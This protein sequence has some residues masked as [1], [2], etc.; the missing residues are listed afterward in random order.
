MSNKIE[1]KRYSMVQL[2]EQDNY[3]IEVP[4]IQRDY[5]QGRENKKEIRDQFLDALFNYLDENIPFRDLDFI[6]GNIEKTKENIKFIPLDGQQRLTTLFLLHWYLAMKNETSTEHFNKYF[7]TNNNSRFIYNTRTSSSEFINALL[8]SKIKT[9]EIDE[10]KK[11]SEFIKEQGWFFLSWNLDPTIQA[12]LIMLDS[13]HFKFYNNDNFY[14]RLVSNDKPIITFQY[15]DLMES[16]LSEDLY[17]KM[18]SRGKPLTSFENFKAKLEKHIKALFGD[19]KDKYSITSSAGTLKYSCKDYFSQ[20]I[21]TTW[22][23][24]FW[25]YR[26]LVGKKDIFDE[27]LMNFIRVVLSNQFAVDNPIEI[28]NF[29][30]LI[31]DESA[32][33]DLTTNLSF[34]RL[35]E[36]GCLSKTGIE[37]LIEILDK[38]S[39][40]TDKIKT[41]I[42]DPFY[43]DENKHFE[44]ILKY[45][46]TKSERIIIHGYLKFLITYDDRG[47]NLFQWMRVLHNLIENTR[48][49]S[50]ENCLAAIRSVDKLI[51]EANNILNYL[52][53]KKDRIDFFASWQV[54]EERVKALLIERSD[55]WKALIEKAE[56][57][58]WHKGQIGYLLEFAGVVDYYKSNNNCKWDNDKDKDFIDLITSYLNKSVSL[59]SFQDSNENNDYLVER[60]LLTK[61]DYLVPADYNRYNFSSSKSVSNYQRDYSWKRI[62]RLSIED[63]EMWGVKRMFVKELFDDVNIDWNNLS[64]SLSKVVKKLPD[65]WRLYFIEN[66]ELIRYCKQGFIERNENVLELYNASQINHLHIDM[67]ICNL[68]SMYLNNEADEIFLPFVYFGFEATKGTWEESC[69][70]LSDWCFKRINYII[71]IFYESNIFK[72][73][74]RK[75]KGSNKLQDYNQEICEILQ[76]NKFKW[77]EDSENEFEH[78]FIKNISNEQKVLNLVKDLCKEFSSL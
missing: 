39:N 9:S 27:E 24:L 75:Q 64:K 11:I 57:A 16:K 53:I 26:E 48:V 36:L 60:S 32:T 51:L 8:K 56:K 42:R 77:N 1:G 19:S 28:D 10:S 70:Y 2:F 35:N 4:M 13:I 43:F 76:N 20:Q 72:I 30:S 31:T 49:E 12:S 67:R 46:L 5:A 47:E 41:S 62:L 71:E 73:Q 45:S 33:A 78:S 58:I 17:I 6:Y 21:E 14:D 23:N 69:A 37:F 7:T 44:Q 25:N 34:Y 52:R 68:F 63:V 65:D 40:G 66:P 61:G 59:F 3:I 29:K 22:A 50:D 15:L 38:L 74:F 54:D 18:N 55:S